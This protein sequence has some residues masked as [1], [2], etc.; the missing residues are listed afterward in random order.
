MGSLFDELKKSKLIDKKRAKQLAHEQRVE[1]K[2]TGGDVAKDEQL[3][4]KAAAYDEQKDEERRR[5]REREKEIQAAGKEREKLAEVK[6][7]VASRQLSDDAA[8]PKRW[9]FESRSGSLP[10]LPCN[11]SAMRRLQG[12]E[13]AIVDDPNVSWPR[14]VIVPRE[15]ARTLERIDAGAVR[16]AA[17]S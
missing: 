13:L 10:F 3:A 4:K 6:Q 8:G 14:Y 15:V 7:L 9:H 2:K 12:G 17:G 11:E 16:Y 1:H 5:N